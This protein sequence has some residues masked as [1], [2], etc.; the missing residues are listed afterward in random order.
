MRLFE[1]FRNWRDNN[2]NM[3][4]PEYRKGVALLELT[5]VVDPCAFQVLLGAAYGDT[6]RV[7]PAA[8]LRQKDGAVALFQSASYCI[9]EGID[10]FLFELDVENAFDII[11][12]DGFVVDDVVK[13]LVYEM[14]P[15]LDVELFLLFS[16]SMRSILLELEPRE[17]RLILDQ[18]LPVPQEMLCEA[19]HEWCA[20]HEV[21]ETELPTIMRQC[22]NSLVIPALQAF[23]TDWWISC[24]RAF[25]PSTVLLGKNTLRLP[26]GFSAESAAVMVDTKRQMMITGYFSV[27]GPSSTHRHSRFQIQLRMHRSCDEGRLHSALIDFEIGLDVFSVGFK[28]S[29][30]ENVGANFSRSDLKQRFDFAASLHKDGVRVEMCRSSGNEDI[31]CIHLGKYDLSVENHDGKCESTTAARFAAPLA[32]EKER[33]GMCEANVKFSVKGASNM[34]AITLG[35]MQLFSSQPD[36]EGT[37]VRELTETKIQFAE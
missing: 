4:T 3:K 29:K 27:P 31:S 35:H 24:T 36:E 10:E 30:V 33:S 19:V 32:D 25:R 8:L 16:P 21:K 34:R 14:L 5:D 1:G 11:F 18:P 23:P 22:T 6:A 28:S 12:E 37:M 13:G 17:M 20:Y 7:E 9:F 26:R 2:Y 15:R